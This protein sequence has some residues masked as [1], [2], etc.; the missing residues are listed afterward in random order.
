MMETG[1]GEGLREDARAQDLSVNHIRVR[2]ALNRL[3]GDGMAVRLLC[4]GVRAIAVS[5]DDWEVLFDMRALLAGLAA[6]LGAERISREERGRMWV[7]I[8]AFLLP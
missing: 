7:A 4:K 5:A 1:P 2:D 8:S 6:E 3:V